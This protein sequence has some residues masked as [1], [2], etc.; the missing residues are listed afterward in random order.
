MP[1]DAAMLQSELRLRVQRRIEDGCLPAEPDN[2]VD[3]SYGEG[4]TCS[5]CDQPITRYQVEYHSVDLRTI[6]Y[7]S[8]HLPCYAIW[9]RECERRVADSK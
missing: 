4:D 1:T 9:K 5:V 3:A 6:K 2:Q 8:F 7:L